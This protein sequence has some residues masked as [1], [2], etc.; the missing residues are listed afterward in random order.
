[1]LRERLCGPTDVGAGSDGPTWFF[2]VT[3]LDV[4]A[5]PTG[6]GLLG[7]DDYRLL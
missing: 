1:M 7:A 4:G 2:G 3:Y 6:P 5:L